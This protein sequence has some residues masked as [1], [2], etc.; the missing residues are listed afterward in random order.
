MLPSQG[1]QAQ[2]RCPGE[3]LD[4]AQVAELVHYYTG[5][6]LMQALAALAGEWAQAE[7]EGCVLAVGD[8]VDRCMS[9]G[10]GATDISRCIDDENGETIHGIVEQVIHMTAS[11][12]FRPFL[13]LTPD[14]ASVLS[15]IHAV[16]T[17]GDDSGAP[18]TW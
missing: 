11:G 17:D 18:M 14:E 3:E 4:M 6:T 12:E 1:G 13:A 7:C 10:D 8:A 2:T 15:Q 16:L 9:Y 5:H